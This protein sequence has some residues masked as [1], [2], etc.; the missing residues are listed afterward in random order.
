MGLVRSFTSTR[1]HKQKKYVE[2]VC[3]MVFRNAV[4][5]GA[6]LIAVGC[7]QISSGNDK[8]WDY[9]VFSQQW[10]QSVCIDNQ[11]E[12][13]CSIPL[14]VTSWTVHGVWP[15]H[16]GTLGPNYCNNSWHFD[17]EKLKPLEPMLKQY[18]PNLF[19]DTP[20]TDFWKHEWTKHGTCAASFPPLHTEY[21][22][23]NM[24]LKLNRKLDVYNSLV[25]VGIEPG[26]KN[27]TLDAINKAFA[28]EFGF[29]MKV[30]CFLDKEKEVQY[31]EQVEMCINKQFAQIDCT[32]DNA[33]A[34]QQNH[35]ATNDVRDFAKVS[36]MNSCIS[37][38]PIQYP[39]IKHK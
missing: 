6:L 39:A 37:K 25:E 34:T 5:C 27:Y 9:M 26:L 2:T 23:F 11:K 18:W 10:P 15:T 19:T 32:H 14:N 36:Q 8:G 3:K 13:N 17:E 4:I 28:A 30:L 31:I 21:A 22:Y 12:H 29:T 35:L 1:K 33:L 7:I 20:M 24:G 16:T 38:Y